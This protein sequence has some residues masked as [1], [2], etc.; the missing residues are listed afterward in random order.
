MGKGE[1][2]LNDFSNFLFAQ[3]LRK[4]GTRILMNIY[5]SLWLKLIQI[6]LIFFGDLCNAI[7]LKIIK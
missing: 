6:E 3:R 4:Y 7:M 2:A 5:F 1:T